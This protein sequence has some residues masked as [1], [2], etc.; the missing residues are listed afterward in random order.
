MYNLQCVCMYGTKYTCHYN[1]MCGPI[2]EQH[3]YRCPFECVQ[4]GGDRRKNAGKERLVYCVCTP[5]VQCVLVRAKVKE[6][7]KH[8]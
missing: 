4:V 3:F 6:H 1:C 5:Q 2:K 8:V 7:G